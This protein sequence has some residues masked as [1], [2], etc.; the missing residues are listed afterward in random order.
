MFGIKGAMLVEPAFFFSL[1]TIFK[2]YL[3]VLISL[4]SF[5]LPTKITFHD[6]NLRFLNHLWFTGNKINFYILLS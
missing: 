4:V 1:N 2:I 6:M 5:I 3:S